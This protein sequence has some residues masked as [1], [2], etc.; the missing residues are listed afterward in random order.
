M[1]QYVDDVRLATN[2]KK[3]I[4]FYCRTGGNVMSP[5][6]IVEFIKGGN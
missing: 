4:K 6:D 1:G 5:E 3:T 2:N